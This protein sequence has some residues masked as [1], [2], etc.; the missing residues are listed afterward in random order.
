VSWRSGR[1]FAGQLGDDQVVSQGIEGFTVRPEDV[2]SPVAATLLRASAGR[3]LLAAVEEA[4]R[5][6]TG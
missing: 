4:A 1:E 5:D 6:L 3:M 2:G